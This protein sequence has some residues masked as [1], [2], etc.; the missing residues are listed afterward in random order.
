MFLMPT[1]SMTQIPG[2]EY[3]R[4]FRHCDDFAALGEGVKNLMM[5]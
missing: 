1:V 5:F 2:G 4:A 3:G